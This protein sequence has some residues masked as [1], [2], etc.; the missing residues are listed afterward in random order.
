MNVR[1]DH[2]SM[3]ASNLKEVIMLTE[4]QATILIGGQPILVKQ[5]DRV[6]T[7]GGDAEQIISTVA[8]WLTS[9]RPTELEDLY[10]TPLD[11]TAFILRKGEV[12]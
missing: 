9:Y 2:G 11:V 7:G 8:D 3:K 5:I 1:K 10:C 4:E 6:I 12:L